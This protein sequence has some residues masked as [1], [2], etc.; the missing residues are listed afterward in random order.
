MK[1]SIKFLFNRFILAGLSIWLVMIALSFMLFLNNKKYHA[2]D[3]HYKYT[4]SLA[5]FLIFVSF[6]FILL[7]VCM[8]AALVYNKRLQ[9]PR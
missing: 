9:N 1:N 4:F 3:L 2:T 5:S 8:V 7:A 6:F